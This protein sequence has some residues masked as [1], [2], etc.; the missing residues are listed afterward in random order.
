MCKEGLA[1]VSAR[2]CLPLLLMVMFYTYLLLLLLSILE[3][4]LKCWCLGAGSLLSLGVSS[5]SKGTIQHPGP[6]TASQPIFQAQWERVR[7]EDSEA[8]AECGG[9]SEGYQRHS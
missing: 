1:I 3:E 6:T 5:V 4:S 8:R 2:T 7:C 9:V